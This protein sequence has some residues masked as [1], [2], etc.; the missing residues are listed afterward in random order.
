MKRSCIPLCAISEQIISAIWRV[1]IV[2]LSF[3]TVSVPEAHAE[4]QNTTQAGRVELPRFVYNPE[5]P[6]MLSSHSTQLIGVNDGN[7][8]ELH[9]YPAR[10][11]ITDELGLDHKAWT[12]RY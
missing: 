3:S 12:E 6:L 1:I 8:Y 9:T 10:L 7:A 2:D 11:F 5:D 4:R